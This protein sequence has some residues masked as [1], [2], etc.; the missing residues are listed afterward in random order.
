MH[1][2]YSPQLITFE[3]FVFPV[4][5]YMIPVVDNGISAPVSGAV[6]LPCPVQGYPVPTVT[7]HK[8]GQEISTDSRHS[9]MD[10][11]TLLIQRVQVCV[12]QGSA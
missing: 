2:Y 10:D 8:D 1:H 9:I 12:M 3:L 6:R 11:G 7:W 5:P 4:P